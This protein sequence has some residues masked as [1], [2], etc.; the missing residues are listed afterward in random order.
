MVHKVLATTAVGVDDI[1]LGFVSK[2]SLG[3]KFKFMPKPIIDRIDLKCVND[4]H[5]DLPHPVIELVM[6]MR[7]IISK[8]VDMINREYLAEYN[9]IREKY[10]IEI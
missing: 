10:D 2:D 6:N 8:Y 7:P 1:T 5:I 9:K 3:F 4:D